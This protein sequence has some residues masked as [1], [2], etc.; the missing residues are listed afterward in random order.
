MGVTGSEKRI[1]GITSQMKMH[2][3]LT[4]R[5]CNKLHAIPTED[6]EYEIGVR[7]VCGI[8]VYGYWYVGKERQEKC[9]HCLW[10]LEGEGSK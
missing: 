5:N 2:T 1:E 9:K 10:I 6:G 3:W 8:R 7:T 4:A